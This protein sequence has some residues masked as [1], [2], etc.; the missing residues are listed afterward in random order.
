MRRA[1]LALVASLFVT[2]VG[3]AEAHHAWNEIDTARSLSL[4][5]VVRS[6]KW[7]NPHASLV[8]ETMDGPARVEWT[9]LMSGPSRMQS[10]GIVEGA[11]AVGR[12]ITIVASPSREDAHTV[13]AN[14][15]RADGV[16]HVLY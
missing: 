5:G 15:I 7:E 16:E 2:G 13:R 8:L 10:H 1:A 11:I 6:L 14:R 3:V 9:V 12:T 4:T